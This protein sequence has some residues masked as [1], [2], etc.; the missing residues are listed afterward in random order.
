[1]TIIVPFASTTITRNRV[2]I[3]ELTA[4]VEEFVTKRKLTCT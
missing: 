1:M 4:S 3:D 2:M